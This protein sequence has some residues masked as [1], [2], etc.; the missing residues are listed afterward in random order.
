[1][2]FTGVS[3]TGI[4]DFGAMDVDSPAI[5]LARLLGDFAG[6][7]DELWTSGF[8]A[9]QDA[10][11]NLDVPPEFIRQLDRAGAVCSILGW[12]RRFSQG[13]QA[14]QRDAIT[15]RLEQLVTRIEY[16]HFT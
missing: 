10:G 3:V 14:F 13:F 15:R 5:D 11:G 4:V 8:R 7:N 2:L 16:S 12:F 1:V 6:E 9:Y